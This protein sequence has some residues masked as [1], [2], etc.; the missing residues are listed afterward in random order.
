VLQNEAMHELSIAIQIVEIVEEEASNA[1]A[2]SIT[3]LELDIGLLSGIEP[4]AL[5]FAMEEAIRDSLLEKTQIIY[6]YIKAVVVCEE[7]CNEFDTD[8]YFNSCPYCNSLKTIFIKGKE[9]NIKSIE[10]LKQ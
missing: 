8:D 4:D 3:K 7:C 2:E 9:L 5:E 10:I 1:D 6:N